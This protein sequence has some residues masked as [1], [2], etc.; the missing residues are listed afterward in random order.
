MDWNVHLYAYDDLEMV[1]KALDSLPHQVDVHVCDGRYMDFAGELPLTPKLESLCEKYHNVHY[2]APDQ[3]RLPFGDRNAPGELRSSVH[4]KA[5]WVNYEVLPQDEW[6]LKLDSD[7]RLQK[8]DVDL[9]ALEERVR[10]CP[11]INRVDERIYVGR[12]WQPRHWTVWI[13]DCLLPREVISRDMALDRLARLHLN[14]EY[15]PVR[16]AYREH[17]EDNQ[18]VIHN[19]GAER[20]AE[21]QQRRIGHLQRLGREDRAAEL[22]DRLRDE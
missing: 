17:L 8:W 11:V 2:H 13:D 15:R 9:E 21:Y 18:I 1:H 12:L 19:A 7:E 16:F 4:E 20:P 6:T 5:K 10:Y 14:L 3:D 22:E